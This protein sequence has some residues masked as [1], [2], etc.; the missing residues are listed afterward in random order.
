MEPIYI[1]MQNLVLF[2]CPF[3][4]LSMVIDPITRKLYVTLADSLVV[5]SNGQ[6]EGILF[7]KT[8][9]SSRTA[10]DHFTM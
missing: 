5:G 9:K 6:M 3:V 2:L 10:D 8:G 1:A 7:R 4:F